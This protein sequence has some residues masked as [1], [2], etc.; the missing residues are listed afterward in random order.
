LTKSST[1]I[2]VAAVAAVAAFGVVQTPENVIYRFYLLQMKD[3]NCPSY[4]EYFS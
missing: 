3:G 1:V 2:V 4:A